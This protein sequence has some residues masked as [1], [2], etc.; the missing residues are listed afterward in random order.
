MSITWRTAWQGQDIVV[1]RDDAEVDR[2]HAPDIERVLLVHRGSGDSPNDLVRAVV[3]LGADLLVFPADTGFAGRVHFER[4]AFW[5]EQGCVYWVNETRAPL[6]MPMRRSRWLLGFGA[7]A[8]MRV[9]RAEL[10]TVISRWPL[11]GPQTWEQR[12]WRRIECARLFAPA[13]GTRLRA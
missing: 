1:Y 3:E 8:F 12:K 13:D 2:L 6:P 10:D 11:Q 4:Q 7:P 5:A 9:A